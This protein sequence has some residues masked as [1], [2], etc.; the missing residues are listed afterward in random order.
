MRLSAA[1]FGYDMVAD[2]RL[3]QISQHTALFSLLG[4]DYGGDGRTTFALPDLR[5]VAPR[6]RN[7]AALNYYVC[8][9]G[10]YPSRNLSARV[11]DAPRRRMHPPPP[12]PR[13]TLTGMTVL[14][15]G[16]AGFIGYH[17][18]ERLLA[19]GDDVVGFDVVDDAYDVRLKEDRLRRLL[20]H[21]R[22]QHVR[23]DLASADRVDGAFAEARPTHVIHMA[24]RADARASR[25]QPRAYV[26]SN[27]VGF[28]NVLE[29]CR[30]HEVRHLTYASSASVYGA[31][32]TMPSSVHQHVDHPLNLYA[33]SKQANEAMA[34]TYA[35]LYDLPT[36]GLRLFTVYGPWGRPDWSTS[37]SRSPSSSAR[38]STSTTTATSA[39][40]SPTSTTSS[41]SSCGSTTSRPRPIP[42]GT[43]AR[44]TP[45]AAAR[46][47]ASTTSAPARPW[48]SS[49]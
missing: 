1:T 10:L 16:T 20:E 18:A 35:H 39:A 5:D 24:A 19:R 14:V 3:L 32:A 7:G 26:R 41:R 21:D 29:A 44:R 48:S 22:Y 33:A 6:S 42:T 30:Q 15:T 47:G 11:P 38:T 31:N 46:H 36:T 13:S 45:P 28:A 12:A 25:A 40:T 43:T 2:G 4:T 9:Q 17:V 49:A 23:A 27:V 8:T 34:H 37:S